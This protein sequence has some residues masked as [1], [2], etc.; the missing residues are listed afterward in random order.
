MK[1]SLSALLTDRTD[2][3]RETSF[4]CNAFHEKFSASMLC[5]SMEVYF[6][7][8]VQYELSTTSG[9]CTEIRLKPPKSI[10]L[11]RKTHNKSYDSNE[12]L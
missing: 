12:N 2:D 11:R 7:N 8:A 9:I 1:S 10:Q 4:Y 6:V 3:I 5:I